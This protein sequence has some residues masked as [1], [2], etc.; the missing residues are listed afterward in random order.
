[1]TRGKLVG[2][3]VVAVAVGVVPFACSSPPTLLGAGSQC[4]QTTDCEP[5]LFCVQQKNKPSVCSKDLTSTVSVEDAAAP[6]PA[7][8]PGGDGGDA[9]VRGEAGVTGA[10]DGPPVDAGAGDAGQGDA[11][12]PREASTPR[13]TQPPDETSTPDTGP[14]DAA[15]DAGGS[16]DASP[17]D[18]PGD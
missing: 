3:A 14:T 8:P 18:G 12:P 5:D 2:A 11:S 15:R 17:G 10:G 1:M 13:D 16:P 6:P 9:A 7:M 4:F